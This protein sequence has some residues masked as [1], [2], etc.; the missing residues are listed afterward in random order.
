MK[1]KTIIM[2]LAA[3]LVLALT[4]GGTLAFLQD[5]KSDTQDFTGGDHVQITSIE[6]SAI[7]DV[8]I[9]PGRTVVF[10]PVINVD[11]TVDAYVFVEFD[12]GVDYLTLSAATLEGW[13]ALPGETNVYYR[14]VAAKSGDSD[15]VINVFAG[16]Q[17]TF[18]SDLTN[19]TVP[20]GTVTISVKAYAIQKDYVGSVSDAWAAVQS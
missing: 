11:N 2:I 14:E 9:I 15:N 5:S 13:T 6:H 16:G 20:A 7:S 19:E 12:D 4:I 3:A 18:S 1:K 8:K 17:I 10:D